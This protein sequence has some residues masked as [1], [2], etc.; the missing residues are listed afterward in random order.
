[1]DHTKT[2]II[3]FLPST[4]YIHELICTYTHTYTRTYIHTY[5]HYIFPSG[6]DIESSSHISHMR[7]SNDQDREENRKWVSERIVLYLIQNL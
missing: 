4:S 3:Y 7:N 1:M 2:I 6:E 5:T